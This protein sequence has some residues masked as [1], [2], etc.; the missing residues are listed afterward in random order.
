[1][2]RLSQRLQDSLAAATQVASER[3]RSIRI[4]RL[5]CAEPYVH[6]RYSSEMDKTCDLSKRAALTEAMSSS[7]FFYA[8]K[9]DLLAI[10]IQGETWFQAVL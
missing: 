4:I 3:L 1:M 7:S 10:G 5:H 2:R 9:L 6:E 8:A